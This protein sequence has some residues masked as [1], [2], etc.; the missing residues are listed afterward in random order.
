[1]KGW[2][3]LM[4]YS[5]EEYNSMSD[6]QKKQLYELL[7]KVR[8]LKSKKNQESTK[9]LEAGMVVLEAQTENIDSKSL[10]KNQQQGWALYGKGNSTK[11]S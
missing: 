9:K 11:Q 10:A 5:I 2:I 7:H 3:N 4:K 8:L 6:A 1:M